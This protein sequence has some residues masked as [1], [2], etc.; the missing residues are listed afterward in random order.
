M[1][2]N[3]LSQCGR[4]ERVAV[5]GV[6]PQDLESLIAEVESKAREFTI[7]EGRDDVYRLEYTRKTVVVTSAEYAAG[8]QFTRVVVC[9]AG[10]SWGEE[11]S[12]SASRL[13]IS[14]LYLAATRAVSHI[15]CVCTTDESAVSTVLRSAVQNGVAYEGAARGGPT[16][17][18]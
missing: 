12:A 5:L 3:F 8:L 16:K 9:Y 1:A 15:A 13:A 6:G 17:E 7:I 4:D 11:N 10:S 14:Q 18:I 2:R